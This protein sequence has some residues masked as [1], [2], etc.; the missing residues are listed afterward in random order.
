MSGY[1]GVRA[2]ILEC[3]FAPAAIL[4][5]APR[6]PDAARSATHPR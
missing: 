6:P 3:V 4:R 5:R 1:V 2:G